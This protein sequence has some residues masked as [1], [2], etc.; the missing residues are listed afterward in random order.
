MPNENIITLKNTFSRCGVQYIFKPDN[1]KY[2]YYFRPD[3]PEF[4]NLV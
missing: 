4:Q 1:K 2:T 3:E